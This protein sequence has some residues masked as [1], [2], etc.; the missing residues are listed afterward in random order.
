MSTVTAVGQV[1]FSPKIGS[2]SSNLF[3]SEGDL[4]QLYT[5]DASS[6]SCVP[7]FEAAGYTP[8]LLDFVV[9][10]SRVAEG[11]AD[12]RDVKWYF[13]DTE[14]QFGSG[15]ISTGSFSG[16]FEKVTPSASNGYVYP[17][18]KIKKNLVAI[19]NFA[20]ATIKA[21]GRIVVGNDSDTIQ[22]FIT[23]KIQ[24][25]T[26]GAVNLVKIAAV[27]AVDGFAISTKGG[28]VQIKAVSYR[29][30]RT[31]VNPT[32]L[33]Y[34]W[35]K[36]T[37]GQWVQITN[38]P[39]TISSDGSTL[40][41]HEADILVSGMYKVEVYSSGTLFGQDTQMV[42]DASDCY[43]VEFHYDPASA[44]ITDDPAGNHSV[45][46]QVAVVSRKTGQVIVQ[47]ANAQAYF[48]VVDSAGNILNSGQNTVKKSSQ[49]VT[50]AMVQQAESGVQIIV[51]VDVPF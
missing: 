14:I 24:Q 13:N 46:V 49:D 40:T 17:G 9:T 11:L 18:L 12:V 45:N 16:Y 19:A 15:N 34:K 27:S 44:T 25:N 39:E 41:V 4:S 47:K 35:F 43:L 23:A 7:D 48:T 22:A 42:V 6:Y 32:S 20:P 28:S 50:L 10:S 38:G 29:A 1:A 21:T 37:A 30:G 2:Y 8:P 31:L 3:C 26:G 5:G 51:E 33:T 36:L